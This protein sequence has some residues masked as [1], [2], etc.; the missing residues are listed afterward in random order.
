MPPAPLIHFAVF[1]LVSLV[2]FLAILRVALRRR[3]ERPTAVE[4]A[5]ISFIVVVVGMVFAKWGATHGWHWAVYYGVPAATTILAPPLYFRMR[6]REVVEY[7]IMASLNAPVIHVV[8]SLFL[9]WNE[10][11]P[12]IHVPSL[13]S[14]GIMP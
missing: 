1:V 6:G 9:D 2:V 3:S 7:L 5:A 13:K 4:L 10:Y 14:L 11:M 8:F 12:F